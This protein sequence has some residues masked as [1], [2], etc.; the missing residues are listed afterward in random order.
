MQIRPHSPAWYDRLATLQSGYY[1]PW[2]SILPPLNGEDTCFKLV[3]QHLFSGADVLDAGCGHGEV[4]LEFASRCRTILAYDRVADYIRLAEES[5]R[6]KG[7]T[8]VT[9]LCADSSA[10]ANEGKPRIPAEPDAFGLLISRRG[11]LNWIEDVRRVARPG[12]V[13]IQL[14]PQPL[15]A[16]PWNDEL[17]EPLRIPAPMI[18][19]FR[20]VIEPRLALGGLALRRGRFLW[21][22]IVD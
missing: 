7:I 12:A 17:P 19:S 11:P 1:Y 13:S 4:A 15:P 3:A 2:K 14:N 6:Q 16:P 18:G 20:E 10:E 5:A 8:N 22:A 21:K 9:F